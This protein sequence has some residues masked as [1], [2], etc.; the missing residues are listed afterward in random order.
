MPPLPSVV[1]SHPVPLGS[2]K[3]SSPTPTY[4]PWFLTGLI[5]MGLNA[6]FPQLSPVSS[7]FSPL[8]AAVLV[9]H[10]VASWWF[11]SPGWEPNLVSLAPLSHTMCLNQQPIN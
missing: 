2:S 3:V 4:T 10:W 9:L 5:L 6:Y 7:L 8:Q 1:Q 11:V